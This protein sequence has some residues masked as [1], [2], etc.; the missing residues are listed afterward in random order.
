[1]V[2]R[3]LTR[4]CSVLGNGDIAA[5]ASQAYAEAGA[6]GWGATWER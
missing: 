5:E 4:T 6:D 1:M 2:G 3:R